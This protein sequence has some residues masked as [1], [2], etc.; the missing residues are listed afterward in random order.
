MKKIL[1]PTDFSNVANNAFVHALGLAKLVHG[2]LIL[3]HT[4]ELPIIDNQFAPQNYKEV[5][6]SLELANFDKFKDEIPKLRQLAIENNCEHIKMSHILM[7]G[8]LIYNAKE[9]IKK[10]AID[11]VVM[12]TSGASGWKE[13]FL[14]TNTGEAIANLTI[15]VLSI[16]ESAKYSKIE[17]IGFTTRFREKDKEALSN[18]IKIAKSAGAIVK[19]LYVETKNSDNTKAT[20]KDWESHFKNESVQFYILPSDNVNETIEEFITHQN[21]DILAMLTYKRNFFQWMF[22][23]SF[24][25]KMSYHCPIP[26][27]ALHEL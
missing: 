10:D 6:D 9:I 18:V 27:L 11:F 17:T 25:E 21:I 7:D 13:M 19:C 1:F 23:T 15:P 4:Y 16:P 12:G 2:E 24:T 14:G 22:S 5:F 8:D 20:Y 26:I 3:L